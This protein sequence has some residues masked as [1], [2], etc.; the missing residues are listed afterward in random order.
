MAM[1]NEH[2]HMSAL[3]ALFLYIESDVA[4]MHI[5]GVN[6]YKGHIPFK[7]YV[8]F[9]ESKLHLIPRY[10]QRAAAVPLGIGH[11][12][13]EDDVNFDIRNHIHEVKLPAPATMAQLRRYTEKVISR[14]LDPDKPL[15][16][17]YL[18]YGLEKKQTAI[19][20]RMHHC[21]AD[22]LSSIQLMMV[23]LDPSPDYEM[24]QKPP[25]I[26][27]PAAG[28]LE[29]V[30]EAVRDDIADEAHRWQDIRHGLGELAKVV[31]HGGAGRALRQAAR[32]A[33]EYVGPLHRLP[34]NVHQLEGKKKL[35]WCAYPLP[36]LKTAA[37]ALGGTVNDGVLTVVGGG[38]RS[39]V[40]GRGA[41]VEKADFNVMVPVSVRDGVADMGNEVSVKPVSIPLKD[42][43]PAERF[44]Q[45]HEQ[46]EALKAAHVADGIHVLV[47]LFQGAPPVLQAQLGKLVQHPTVTTALS[48]ATSFPTMNALCTNVPGPQMPLYTLG[49]ECTAVHPYAP[50]VAEMGLG[51]VC[52]SYNGMIYISAVA[53]RAAVPDM[54]KLKKA[55]DQS[56]A[57]LLR[58]ARN[59][60]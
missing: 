40:K 31:A 10:R 3:D 32:V 16:D 17:Q 8:D 20:T 55:L 54:H 27:R 42:A 22:G 57:A 13:W 33:R 43:D 45:I 58:S 46:T 1:G 41:D 47:R 25:Y 23:M 59:R 49:H 26:P 52:V 34:F 4:P 30:V 28:K 12:A 39:Y 36:E 11:P 56:Y 37:R 9:L 48:Y 5:G 44:R 18:I 53:D 21:M 6:L 50:V 38:V 35:G 60:V 15:W 14:P 29:Q 51:F 24:G 7:K 2:D 19:L